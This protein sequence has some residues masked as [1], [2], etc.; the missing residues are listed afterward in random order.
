MET[1]RVWVVTVSTCEYGDT[2]DIV[3]IVDDAILKEQA[4]ELAF[5]H[6]PELLNSKRWADVEAHLAWYLVSEDGVTVVE[7]GNTL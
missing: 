4:I 6:H 7:A 2:I 5:D 3:V 1:S